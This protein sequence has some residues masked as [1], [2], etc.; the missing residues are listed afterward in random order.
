MKEVVAGVHKN[1]LV[2]R[3]WLLSDAVMDIVGVYLFCCDQSAVTELDQ[4]FA[5]MREHNDN[6]ASSVRLANNLL[7]IHYNI[8]DNVKNNL[9][10]FVEHLLKA[11]DE[12]R[13]HWWFYFFFIH[14]MRHT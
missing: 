6:S 9:A 13:F 7:E 10:P 1:E 14:Y 8:L 12:N 4:R 11:P 3:P 2:V 5:Y